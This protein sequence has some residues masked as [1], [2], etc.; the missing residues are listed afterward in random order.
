MTAKKI[1]ILIILLFAVI[2]IL[3]FPSFIKEKN[4][5][6]SLVCFSNQCLKT[7]IAATEQEK[8]EG[9]MF[10]ESLPAD[11]GMLFVFNQANLHSFWMK[12]TYLP[13]DIIWI[14]NQH[15]VVHIEKAV[16]CPEK[17]NCPLYQSNTPAKY[18]LEANAGFI[19]ANEIKIGDKVEIGLNN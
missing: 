19:Q 4:I 13:L 18:V 15:R 11:Q 10:R 9:L 1:F 14:N 8:Q 2:L 7:E 6:D 3:L 12:D 16:P 17:D 5:P